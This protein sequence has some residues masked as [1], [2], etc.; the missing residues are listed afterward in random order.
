M[1]ILE[2]AILNAD[3]QGRIIVN[4]MIV[5]KSAMIVFTRGILSAGA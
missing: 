5:L 1:P 3:I 4:M 2:K